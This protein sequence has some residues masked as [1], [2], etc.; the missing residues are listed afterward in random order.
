MCVAYKL[1]VFRVLQLHYNLQDHCT[2][3]SIRGLFFYRVYTQHYADSNIATTILF[4]P[5]SVR[6]YETLRYLVK[7]AI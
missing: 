6:L 5:S 1:V 7:T 4:V 2:Y 3:T